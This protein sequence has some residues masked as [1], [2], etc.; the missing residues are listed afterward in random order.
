MSD[1]NW[2]WDDPKE[3]LARG[4]ER[5]TAHGSVWGFWI[6]TTSKSDATVTF[7]VRA[8]T[9]EDPQAGT[10]GSEPH[11]TAYVKW[12]SCA[13]VQFTKIGEDGDGSLHLCG[14]RSFVEHLALMRRIYHKAFEVMGCRPQAG[15]E[16]PGA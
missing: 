4:V 13:D 7:D 16:W 12:D 11:M 14:V 5:F 1:I 8:I 6:E 9:S 3:L 15:E 2:R 10:F